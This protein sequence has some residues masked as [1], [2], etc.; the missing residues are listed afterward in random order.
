MGNDWIIDVL[1]DLKSFAKAND[2][3]A[4]AGQLDETVLVA[5]TEIGYT[6][7]NPSTLIRGECA[8]NRQVSAGIGASKHA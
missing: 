4:L 3:P 6:S 8:A 7:G 2:L 1:A 5:S